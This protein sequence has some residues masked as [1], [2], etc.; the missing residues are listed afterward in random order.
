MQSHFLNL[1]LLY[2]ESHSS[3]LGLHISLRFVRLDIYHTGDPTMT[4][5]QVIQLV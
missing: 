5:L 4:H 2:L 1:I 3:H